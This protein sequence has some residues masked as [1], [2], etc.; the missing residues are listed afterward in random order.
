MLLSME[1]S[2]RMEVSIVLGIAFDVRARGYEVMKSGSSYVR[3]STRGN[4]ETQS[5][6]LIAS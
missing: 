6:V 4:G 1:C 3:A 5:A 2:R